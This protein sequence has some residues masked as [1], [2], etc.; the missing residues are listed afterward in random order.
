MSIHRPG[1][2][3]IH[4]IGKLSGKIDEKGPDGVILNVGGVGYDVTLPLNTLAGLS[5]IG[6]NASLWIHTHVREDELRLFGFAT[7]RDR[8]V[9]RT[10]LKIAGVGPKLALAV[11]GALS[12]DQLARV[13]MI[14]DTKRL[15]TIPGIGKKTAERIVLELGGKI[16]L[17][18]DGSEAA[19]VGKH[20]E[21]ASAL[22]N[23]GFKPAEVERTLE[24]IGK[25]GEDDEPFEA[26]L[27]KALGLIQKK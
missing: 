18:G 12:G 9:F 2:I 19:A 5:P 22:K 6:E 11:I 3:L 4:M 24:E 15:S 7:K 16:S 8:T 1:C 17:E 21:L 13:V 26:M 25:Q 20:A 14:G 27:R 23:L 10:L